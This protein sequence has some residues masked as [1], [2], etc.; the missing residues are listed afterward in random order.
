[1]F[2]AWSFIVHGWCKYDGDRSK[3]D[4]EPNDKLR[5]IQFDKLV[6]LVAGI[7]DELF[8]QATGV[9]DDLGN[10]AI[11]FPCPLAEMPGKHGRGRAV[12]YGGKAPM[13]ATSLLY[14]LQ[15]D[16]TMH[17]F[18][19]TP[20]KD[21][22]NNAGN[23]KTFIEPGVP[24]T[25]RSEF[26]DGFTEEEKNALYDLENAIKRLGPG[27]IRALGTH[28][29]RAKTVED[30]KR[31]FSYTSITIGELL[32][33]KEELFAEITQRIIEYADEACR[34]SAG[35]RVDYE[36]AWKRLDSELVETVK[37]AFLRKHRPANEI[38]DNDEVGKL[39]N[40]AKKLLALARY[41][42][43]L[44]SDRGSSGSRRGLDGDA[45]RAAHA[46]A[47]AAGYNGLPTTS[48]H[49]FEVSGELNQR[50][51]EVLKYAQKE[52]SGN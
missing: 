32:T 47:Q 21:D 30:I 16:G 2:R 9:A 25:N 49:I 7:W 26:L 23:Y 40:K 31:E 33:C 45:L 28:E 51:K 5:A 35:N 37:E 39:S 20:P 19:I 43:A 8:R 11:T 13:F 4:G 48:N 10:S 6:C 17:L 24:I 14:E 36:K 22:P 1:M 38:W 42:K 52:L 44:A 27:E 29:N 41:L 15:Q 3:V 46:D 12:T 50:I 34:K 18:E